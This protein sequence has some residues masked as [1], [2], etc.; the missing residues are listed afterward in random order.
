MCS[1][2]Q[3]T[4]LNLENSNNLILENVSTMK[5]IENTPL[6]KL[7]DVANMAIMNNFPMFATDVFLDADG[8][9]TKSIFLKNNVFTNVKKVVNKGTA[10]NPTAVVE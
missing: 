5:P 4:H 7:T 10:L 2:N 6:I 3:L 8:T 1:S 9:K